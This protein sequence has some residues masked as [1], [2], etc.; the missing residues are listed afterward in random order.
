LEEII[1]RSDLIGGHV[2]ADDFLAGMGLPGVG[3][4]AGRQAGRQHCACVRSCTA[5]NSGVDKLD[6]RI[7]LVEDLDHG[8]QSIRL[9]WSDPPR[10]DLNL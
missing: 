4:I 3:R 9:A 6:I 5:S 8:V 7:F 10:E 2:R 1:E